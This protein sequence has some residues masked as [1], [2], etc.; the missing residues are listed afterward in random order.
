MIPLLNLSKVK[1]HES[2]YAPR[3]KIKKRKINK[4][5]PKAPLNGKKTISPLRETKDKNGNPVLKMRL[6]LRWG[7]TNKQKFVKKLEY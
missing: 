1:P 4:L 5:T 7:N 3:E 6:P 2:I